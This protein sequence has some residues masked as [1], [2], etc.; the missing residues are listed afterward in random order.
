MANP[1]RENRQTRPPLPPQTRN[2]RGM[3]AAAL[4]LLGMLS[5]CA[6]PLWQAQVATLGPEQSGTAAGPLHRAGQPCLICHSPTGDAVPL[7]TAGTVYRDPSAAVPSSGIEVLL[8]DA[9]RRTYVAHTNCAGNFFVFPSEYQPQLPLWVSLR[10][11]VSGLRAQVDMESPMHRD[12]DCGAC[13]RAAKG[14]SSAGP[15][16]LSDD[17]ARIPALPSR[18][19]GGL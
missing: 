3:P 18:P 16:F 8:I 4:F 7:T 17:P 15:V 13:H 10:Y 6:D 5:A 2:V 9:A 19:C 1:R 12:G 11:T 14:P